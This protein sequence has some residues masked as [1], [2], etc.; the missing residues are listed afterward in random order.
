MLTADLGQLISQLASSNYLT[1]KLNLVKNDFV[2]DTGYFS[3]NALKQEVLN[4]TTSLK[5]NQFNEGFFKSTELLLLKS[6]KYL[7]GSSIHPVEFCIH[8]ILTS[9][10]LSKD[11]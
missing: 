2:T 8:D 6:V 1:T 11:I 7:E 9:K 4:I 3:V 5:L 10:I